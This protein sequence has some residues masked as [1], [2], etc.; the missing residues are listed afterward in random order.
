MLSQTDDLMKQP[1]NSTSKFTCDQI[2]KHVPRHSVSLLQIFNYSVLI[3][4]LSRKLKRQK[5][6]VSASH[7]LRADRIGNVKSKNICSL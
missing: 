6:K 5:L 7:S 1:D 2:L 3:F 4:R